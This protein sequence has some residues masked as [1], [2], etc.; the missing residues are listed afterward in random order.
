MGMLDKL[1]QLAWV[2]RGGRNF[3]PQACS[4]NGGDVPGL[5]IFT[6]QDLI[7]RSLYLNLNLLCSLFPGFE[8]DKGIFPEWKTY[9]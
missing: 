2:K 3:S 9:F 7:L 6:G 5:S 4:T 8:N 1:F